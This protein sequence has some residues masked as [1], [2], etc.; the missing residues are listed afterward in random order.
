MDPRIN[1][2]LITYR[3]EELRASMRRSR[4][5]APVRG[6]RRVR[7]ARRVRALQGR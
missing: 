4:G 7:L 5:G 1:R 3:T 2:L 6:P